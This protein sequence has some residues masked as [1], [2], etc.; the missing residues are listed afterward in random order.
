MSLLSPILYSF[1]FFLA[2]A[3]IVVCL[4]GMGIVKDS[5][6]PVPEDK[7]LRAKNQARNEEQKR[8]KEKKKVK[9]TRK[10]KRHETTKKNHREA[11]KAGLPTPE[12]PETSV[13]EIVCVEEPHWLNEITDEEDEDEV[14]PPVGW[15]I[16]V[17][18]GSRARGGSEA[19]EGSQAPGGARVAPFIIVDDEEDGAPQGG[20]VPPGPQE[21]ERAPGGGSET[22]QEPMEPVGPIEPRPAAGADVEGSAEALWAGMTIGA[23]VPFV[24]EM[25]IHVTIPST[26]GGA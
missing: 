14:I 6:P 13:S 15:G 19:P 12:A 1:P 18:E 7:E 5:L 26:P 3:L 10:A 23:P 24:G 4:H 16:E 9:S 25:G 20:S 22:P 21:G 2:L 8:A 17:L 11:E